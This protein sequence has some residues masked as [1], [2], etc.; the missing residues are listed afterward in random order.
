[1]PVV[2]GAAVI[3]DGALLACRRTG[4][5]AL[6][7]RWEFPGGKVEPGESEA[8]A[9]RR[10]CR[11]ELALHVQ[12]GARLGPDVQL[13]GAVLRV[14]RCALADGGEPRL[15]DH[16]AARWLGPDQLFGVPWI[17]ADLGL[18]AEAQALLRAERRARSG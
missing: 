15:T 6:A 18:V 7:G 17:D 5:H 1:M 14:Y 2:V 3:R 10:E 16:D 13:P 4:P 9:L 11:E 8:A 12:V